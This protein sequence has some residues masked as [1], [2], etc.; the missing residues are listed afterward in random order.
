L[1]NI[2]SQNSIVLEKNQETEKLIVPK[3]KSV[4]QNFNFQEKL[5]KYD[6]KK[7]LK[8]EDNESSAFK[9]NK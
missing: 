6:A 4:V 2:T 5:K 3:V 1:Q 8:L 7:L 9:L